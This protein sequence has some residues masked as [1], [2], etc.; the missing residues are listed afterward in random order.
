MKCD[1]NIHRD[2]YANVVLSGGNTVFPGIAERLT[3]EISEKAQD[4]TVNVIAPSYS[5][6]SSWLGGSI[7]AALP[8]FQPMWISKAEYDESGP[9]VVNRKCV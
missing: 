5:K 6:Y 4:M 8:T 3:K 9:S 2:L 1:V 7:L